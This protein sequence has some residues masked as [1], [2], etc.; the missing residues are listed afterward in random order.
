MEAMKT[1]FEMAAPEGIQGQPVQLESGRLCKDQQEQIYATLSMVSAAEKEISAVIVELTG[2]DITG[3]QIEAQEHQYLDLTMS[4]G[5]R[6]GT[7]VQIR[8]QDDR[9]RKLSA[10]IRTVVFADGTMWTLEEQQRTNAREKRAAA[11]EKTANKARKPLIAAL[12]LALIAVL[13]FVGVQ[14]FG[15]KRYD[16]KVGD[17]I[18]FGHYPQTSE[19]TDS[20][21]IEW[22]VLDV[23]EDRALV[24]SKYAL[25]AKP[26]HTE[27]TDVT[28]E[29]CTLRAW[30]NNEF[31]NAAFSA[32]EQNAILMTTCENP[33]VD[34]NAIADAD[35]WG[36]LS[37]SVI[38]IGCTATE[39][40][41][42]LLNCEEAGMYFANDE[43]RTAVPTAYAVAN[44][45]NILQDGNCWWWLRSPG[46][47]PSSAALVNY[48][49][50]R[51]HF[52]V[53]DSDDAVRPALWVDL[54]S[55]I[56][57]H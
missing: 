50:T 51:G 15:P 18:S 16:A 48:D 33:D 31:I 40:S 36:S 46:S 21:P 34:W 7:E 49:G 4:K 54:K 20:T 29:T 55:D 6:C 3:R 32:E 43:A 25:D 1:V 24:I 19:G 13:V 10:S 23:Q 12:A 42:F 5:D 30:L 11:A 35:G 41:V 52:V 37:Q 57:N 56:L 17:I 9:V 39:D 14:L 53:N 27:Q 38:G 8:M 22:V 26:Y 2:S 44:N 47:L 28:W 45:N